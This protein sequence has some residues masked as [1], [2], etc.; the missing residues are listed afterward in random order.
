MRNSEIKAL[1]VEE[2]AEKLTSSQESLQKMKF[3]HSVSPLENPIQIVDLKKH[4]ARLSTELHA[5]TIEAVRG[6]VESGELTNLNAR[7][8]LAS[9]KLPTPMN[10]AKIK[11][12]I[13]QTA[14]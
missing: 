10:L 8:F 14:K 5:K 6:K 7:A 4:I 13:A 1:S 3:S 12:I 9:E 11:K 2:L